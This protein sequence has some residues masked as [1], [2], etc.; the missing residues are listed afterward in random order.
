VVAVPLGQGMTEMWD[1]VRDRV[2]VSGHGTTWQVTAGS[3]E[4]ALAYARERFDDPAV[5]ARAD[6]NRWWPRVTLTVTTDP[7]LA[8]SA[9]PLEEL[10]TVAVPAEPVTPVVPAPDRRDEDVAASDADQSAEEDDGSLPRSL[11]VIFAHQERRHAAIPRQRKRHR[12]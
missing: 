10:A 5:L 7:V 12:A 3:F 2:E 8:D 6:R 9:P 11:E 1:A 4:G